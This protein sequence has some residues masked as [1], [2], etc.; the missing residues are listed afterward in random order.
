MSE[1]GRSVDRRT[2][3]RLSGAALLPALAGCS[4]ETE[5]PDHAVAVAPDRNPEFSPEVLEIES[6]D[7]VEWSW[8][9]DGHTVTPSSIP[10]GASWEGQPEAQDEED[11]YRHTFDTE[12]RY[13][14]HCEFHQ[15][16]GMEGAVVVGDG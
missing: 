4:D 9:S 16:D 10:D 3:L 8:L 12:G 6:G 7:T 13:E 2:V 11:T 5:I 14:Y 1:D 15:E